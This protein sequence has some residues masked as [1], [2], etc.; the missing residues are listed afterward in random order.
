MVRTSLLWKPLY[1]DPVMAENSSLLLLPFPKSGENRHI[2]GRI[3]MP[4]SRQSLHFEWIQS[5][6][7]YSLV[8]STTI[9]QKSLPGI[10]HQWK[11]L[12]SK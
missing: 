8:V 11:V 4:D 2:P 6:K 10:V 7:L 3:P 1:N 12:Y 5:V 9:S